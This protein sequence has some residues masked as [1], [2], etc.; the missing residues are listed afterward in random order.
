M[1]RVGDS[2]DITRKEEA[3]TMSVTLIL[4][5]ITGLNIVSIILGAQANMHINVVIVYW[6]KVI[7]SY[8]EIQLPCG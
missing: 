6:K 1:G 4:A 7:Q 8:L 3:K 2:W 5:S